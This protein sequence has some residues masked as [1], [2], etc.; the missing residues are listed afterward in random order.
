MLDFIKAITKQL[1]DRLD[2]IELPV[3]KRLTVGNTETKNLGIICSLC[4]KFN[5]KNK[6]SLGA[7][8]K[9]C[10]LVNTAPTIS[11]KTK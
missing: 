1:S 7:H 3:L 11:I 5:A 6:A 4:N 8:M 10:R 9:H 2:S